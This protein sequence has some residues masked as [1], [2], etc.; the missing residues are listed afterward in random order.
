MNESDLKQFNA[1]RAWI[2][3]QV[4]MPNRRKEWVP[5]NLHHDNL[6]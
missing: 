2:V 3:M 4:M 1:Y 6:S 5:D